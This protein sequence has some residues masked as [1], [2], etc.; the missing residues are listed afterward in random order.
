M[1]AA[2]QGN[3]PPASAPTTV[4][5]PFYVPPDTA[6]ATRAAQLARAREEIRG[7]EGLPAESV[8]QDI[9]V[10]KALTAGRLL[11]VMDIGYSRSL[12]VSCTHCHVEDH[13]EREDSTR[14]Q[15]ARQMSAMVKVINTELLKKVDSLRSEHPV[16]N[17]TTC[18]RGNKKPA[19]DL[20][21]EPP[22]PQG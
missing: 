21:P 10:L 13:W 5:A 14:K 2:C 6:A 3:H 1:L 17:C 19:L 4:T 15:V 7:R 22:K 12:G 18:H 11:A 16:V 8:Y 20:R 9:R